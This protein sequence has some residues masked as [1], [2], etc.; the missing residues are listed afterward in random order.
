MRKRAWSVS[1]LITAVLATVFA[2]TFNRGGI[3]YGALIA[4]NPEKT[5]ADCLAS[6]D[7]FLFEGYRSEDEARTKPLRPWQYVTAVPVNLYPIAARTYNENEEIWFNDGS[8][9]HPENESWTEITFTVSDSVLLQGVSDFF[10][11]KQEQV[12]GT[13]ITWNEAAQQ[14]PIL[15]KYNDN[16]NQFEFVEGLAEMPARSPAT[17][18]LDESGVFWIF[19]EQDAVYSFDPSFAKTTFITDFPY[20]YIASSDIASNGDIYFSLLSTHELEVGLSQYMKE[21]SLLKFSRDTRDISLVS[22]PDHKLPRG[23]NIGVDSKD[24][25]W[26]EGIAYLDSNDTWNLT[27]NPEIGRDI[28]R[29]PRAT[30]ELIDSRGVLWFSRWFDSGH[31]NEGMGWY[32]PLSS[33]GCMYTNLV[34]NNILEDRDG[35][36]WMVIERELYKL[37]T[38]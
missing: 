24:Q 23:I 5:K 7:V 26:L 38:Q 19:I 4:A 1:V 22:I 20:S 28:K 15:A 8:V 34:A 17:I 12:W 9:Y 6:F 35:N 36:I 13:T 30:L 21:G 14:I 29:Y 10:V 32:D 18:L 25:L 31:Q 37:E 3:R 33:T 11:D 2:L 16:T 27:Y